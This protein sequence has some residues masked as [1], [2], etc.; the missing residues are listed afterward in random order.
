MQKT[1]KIKNSFQRAWNKF[2]SLWKFY[3][4]LAAAALLLTLGFRM[5]AGIFEEF[6]TLSSIFSIVDVILQILISIAITTVLIR[7]ARDQEVS[8]DFVFEHKDRFLQFIG[9]SL[10]YQAL[11]IVGTFLLVIPGIYMAIRYQYVKFIILDD[12]NISIKDAFK[13]SSEITEGV[14]W[15]MVLFYI[16]SVGIGLA[17][18]L[19]FGAG[20]L[21]AI[22][23]VML[24]NGFV[25]IHLRKTYHNDF[26]GGENIKVIDVE[27]E[28]AE[29]K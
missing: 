15:R 26:V 14:K 29:E 4:G 3:M 23:I 28:E 21:I 8:W 7:S 1:F 2:K 5:L 22:P 18:L 11:V 9:A 17:G 24:A 16:V 20:L 10:L 6:S 12:K 13:R 19:V 25:Y 27:I